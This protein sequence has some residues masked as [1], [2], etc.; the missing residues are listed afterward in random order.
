[1]ARVTGALTVPLP[2]IGRFKVILDCPP[3]PPAAV[4]PS[5]KGESVSHITSNVG[6]YKSFFL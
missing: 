1:M 2:I 4:V 5:T 6:Q 3:P